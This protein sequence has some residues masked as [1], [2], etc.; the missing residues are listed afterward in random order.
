MTKFKSLMG[1]AVGVVAMALAMAIGSAKSPQDVERNHAESYWRLT[2]PSQPTA[3]RLNTDSLR[4]DFDILASN[5]HDLRIE[6]ARCIVRWAEDT[7]PDGT[8]VITP[9]EFGPEEMAYADSMTV[10]GYGKW[11]KQRG[12]VEHTMCGDTLPTIHTHLT[13][14][15]E[16]PFLESEMDSASLAKSKAPFGVVLGVGDDHMMGAWVYGYHHSK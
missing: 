5:S 15:G 7:K 9:L 14:N 4:Q 8:L 16:G 6:Q 11:N 2:I 10:Y 12:V 3:I 1:L 13:I